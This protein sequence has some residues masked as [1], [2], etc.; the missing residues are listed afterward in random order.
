MGS[1]VE[2]FEEELRKTKYNK[3]TQ[4]HVGLLKAK[5]ARL[6]DEELHKSSGGKGEGYAVRKTGDGTVI[7]LGY[8]SVGKSTLLNA[9]TNAESKV[10]A[11]DFTTLDVIPGLMLHNHA[12]IQVLDVPGIVHGAASGRGRGREVLSVVR[13]ADL[14][15]MLLDVFHPGHLRVLQQ[16]L[17]DSGVRANTSRPDVKISRKMRGGISMA[18]TVPQRHMDRETLET[19]LREY[20]LMNCDVV[21][22]SEVTVEEFIDCI[23]GN[24]IYLPA[25]VVLNKVDMVP[26]QKA[27]EVAEACKVDIMVSAQLGTNLAEL[28]ELIFTRMRLMRVYLKQIG[29][30][31]DMDEPVIMRQGCTVQDVCTRLHRDFVAKFKFS[32]VWGPSSRFPGQKRMLP[33]VLRDQDVLEVHLR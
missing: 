32:R 4:H 9:I 19:V 2:E 29:K 8:P 7:M 31:P 27:R 16:E 33:H 11:Y 30:K 17:Y 13:S 25:I 12:K 26:A 10:G 18:S 5:I 24:R 6:K 23:L 1:R 3:A 20:R 14:V 28:K 22:R 15:L 21:L